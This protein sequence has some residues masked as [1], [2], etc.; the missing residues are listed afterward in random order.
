MVG[1][2]GLSWAVDD[3]GVET[4]RGTENGAERKR[5]RARERESVREG[6]RG[7]VAPGIPSGV[8]AAARGALEDTPTRLAVHGAAVDGYG[9]TAGAAAHWSGGTARSTPI[10]GYGGATVDGMEMGMEVVGGAVPEMGGAAVVGGVVSEMVRGAARD[11]E[12]VVH[13]DAS[14]WKHYAYWVL[15]AA[16]DWVLTMKHRCDMTHLCV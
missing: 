1:E 7:I 11:R 14:M 13:T 15:E 4:V 16:P 2:E 5:A 10:D 12:T 8:T 6:V 3:A 9:G